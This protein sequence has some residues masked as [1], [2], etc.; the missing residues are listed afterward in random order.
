MIGLGHTHLWHRQA[1]TFEM[2]VR[3]MLGATRIRIMSLVLAQAAAFAIPAW[4]LG[5]VL[6]A[7]GTNLLSNQFASLSG[8]DV[9]TGMTPSV[10]HRRV[11]IQLPS[12]PCLTLCMPCVGH[13]HC[14]PPGHRHSPPCLHW[15]NQDIFGLCSPRCLGY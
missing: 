6:A 13:W 2:A 4:V 7:I 15:S 9:D 3:R 12:L 10:S 11:A 1:R 8:V 5:L 14:N